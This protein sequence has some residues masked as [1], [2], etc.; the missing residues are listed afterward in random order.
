MDDLLVFLCGGCF[1][2]DVKFTCVIAEFMLLRYIVLKLQDTSKLQEG[3]SVHS[4]CSGADP[5]SLG[6][7]QEAYEP[8]P[9]SVLDPTF[10]EDISFSSEYGAGVS[11][12]GM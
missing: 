11:V 2:S 12:Y 6:S 8:S 7:F 1:F 9:I 3:S 5:D 10:R 4:L